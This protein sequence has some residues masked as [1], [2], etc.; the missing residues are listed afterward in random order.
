MTMPFAVRADDSSMRLALHGKSSGGSVSAL[1][2]PMLDEIFLLV[3]QSE[4][5]LSTEIGAGWCYLDSWLQLRVE[6]P[7]A[8]KKE[9]CTK[10][11]IIK[12]ATGDNVGIKSIDLVSSLTYRNAQVEANFES[13]IEEHHLVVNAKILIALAKGLKIEKEVWRWETA[14]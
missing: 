11:V 1:L 9:N 6:F 2:L 8:I 3:N 13:L 14:L 7:K 12:W 5:R 4:D 10:F